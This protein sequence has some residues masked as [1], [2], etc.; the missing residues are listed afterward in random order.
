MGEVSVSILRLSSDI[1]RA[2]TIREKPS[3]S[4]TFAF[5][6]FSPHTCVLA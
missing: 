1:S 4:S 5:S 6:A 2:A 3:F